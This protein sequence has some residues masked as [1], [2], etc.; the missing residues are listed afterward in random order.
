LEQTAEDFN[1]SIVVFFGALV[2][3]AVYWFLPKRLGGARHFFKGPV[4]P[5]D[6]EEE[7]KEVKIANRR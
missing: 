7:G 5:D 4:R 2:I 3:A 1:Y 6:E